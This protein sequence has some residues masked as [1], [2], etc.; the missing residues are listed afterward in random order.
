MGLKL[1]H[2]LIPTIAPH[3]IYGAP[4]QAA[5]APAYDRFHISVRNAIALNF[6]ATP[7]KSPLCPH[8]PPQSV[9]SS[10]STALIPP[11]ARTR[12]K[13]CGTLSR[14]RRSHEPEIP[15]HQRG[16]VRRLGSAGSGSHRNRAGRPRRHLAGR[17][18]RLPVH[19]AST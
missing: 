11:P 5:I 2:Q 1:W 17:L 9:L 12:P 7:D 3:L 16:L 6:S 15:Y 14:R 8:H 19:A 10:T 4:R 13:P 18:R